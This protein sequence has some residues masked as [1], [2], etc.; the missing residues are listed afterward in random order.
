MIKSENGVCEI[1]GS[2]ALLLAE[3]STI[4]SALKESMGEFGSAAIPMAV[5]I[6]LSGLMNGT[7]ANEDEDESGEEAKP[8]G[9]VS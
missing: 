3:L 2:G 6:G 1:K 8:E 7:D 4:I 9:M 5:S